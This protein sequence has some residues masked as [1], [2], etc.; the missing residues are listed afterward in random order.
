M[1]DERIIE[2]IFRFFYVQAVAR[3]KF[4]TKIA[5]QAL[6]VIDK[7][8]DAD[9]FDKFQVECFFFAESKTGS[10]AHAEIPV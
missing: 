3:A 7:G 10:A 1:A 8:P 6:L 9:I 5:V 4:E 2:F